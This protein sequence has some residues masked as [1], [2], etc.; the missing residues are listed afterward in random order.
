M[1]IS[2]KSYRVWICVFLLNFCLIYR[3]LMDCVQNPW[4]FARIEGCHSPVHWW[5]SRSWFEQVQVW[6]LLTW[7]LF[8][9]EKLIN[10][11]KCV[12]GR[13]IYRY[14]VVV[15][16]FYVIC[17]ICTSAYF[18]LFIIV[19]IGTWLLFTCTSHLYTVVNTLSYL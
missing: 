4:H 5:N 14:V 9:W 8:S 1:C 3:I 19:G 18:V 7:R 17:K 11:V 2:M 13:I 12:S 15:V 16:D 10:I 6:S